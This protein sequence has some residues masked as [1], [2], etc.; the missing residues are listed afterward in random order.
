VGT[1]LL[2]C[3]LLGL[4][5]FRDALVAS[6]GND[7]WATAVGFWTDPIVLYFL[8]GVWL[9]LVRAQLDR[10]QYS[11]DIDMRT[12][13]LS[14]LTVLIGYETLLYH[15]LMPRWLEALF[16][17]S[18]MAGLGLTNSAAGSRMT[19]VLKLLGDA[20]YSTYLTH[21]FFLAA[22]WKIAGPHRI[23]MPPTVYLLLALAGASVMGLVVY[24]LIEKPML[25]RLQSWIARPPRLVAQQER[26]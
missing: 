22:L 18:L 12:L 11:L 4:V 16:A 24:K 14:L 15:G 20:S 1:V 17:L 2:S 10:R 25:V 13:L 19:G 3:I 7:F 21:L 9:G 26:G 6:I 8:G 5:A 23:D